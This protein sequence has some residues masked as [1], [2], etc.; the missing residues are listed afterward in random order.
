MANEEDV[1]RLFAAALVFEEEEVTDALGLSWT[2]P[3]F[4]RD[5]PER[6]AI[7]A[8][9]CVDIAKTIVTTSKPRRAIRDATALMGV[10]HP[11]SRNSGHSSVSAT[12]GRG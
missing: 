5:T 9:R 11:M 3:S 12:F 1:N 2:L 10:S 7:C 4:V 6:S 8:E